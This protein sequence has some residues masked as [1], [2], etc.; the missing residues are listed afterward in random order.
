MWRVTATPLMRRSNDTP[1]QDHHHYS[2]HFDLE[3]TYR[4]SESSLIS[5]TAQDSARHL[6]FVVSTPSH[7]TS[8]G[9]SVGSTRRRPAEAGVASGGGHSKRSFRW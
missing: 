4:L 6:L 2:K 8:G 7:R 1:R 3:A 9:I 5:T